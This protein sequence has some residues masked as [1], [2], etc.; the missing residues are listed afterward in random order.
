MIPAPFRYVAAPTVPDAAALLREHGDEAKVIAG[1]QS[2][3]PLMKL[4]L[5]TPTV[6]V[7]LRGVGLTGVRVDDGSLVIGAMTT[8][9][10]VARSAEVAEHAP[11]LARA[12]SVVGDPQV[13]N[14]GTIG[15]GVAH[16]DP[17]SDVS[18]ALMALGA[19][20]VAVGPGGSRRELGI[21]DL[22]VGFWTSALA[23]DEVLTEIRVPSAADAGWAYEK[24]T[25][26]AQDW[27]MVAV[28]V[29][30]G[31]V[32]LASMADRIVRAHGT[33]GLLASGASIAEAAAVAA[34]GTDPSSDLRASAAYRR[35]L[36]TVLTADALLAAAGQAT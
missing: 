30:G 32:A 22:F 14:R 26:R 5:A 28:A 23:A 12:A 10:D 36:A 34:E 9:R 24:F 31:R 2:L 20:V 19:T 6:L 21:D 1:G 18:C 29:C 35:H 11:L 17:A 8:Y 33:E 4:R 15:G 3:L 7:D 27:A 13:R 25:I 16:A